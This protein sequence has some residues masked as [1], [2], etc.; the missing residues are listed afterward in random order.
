MTGGPAADLFP[1]FATHRVVTRGVEI[2]ARVGGSGP[3]LLLLHGYPQSHMMWHRVAGPLARHFTLVLPDL[4]GYGRSSCPPSDD[5]HRAYAKRTMALD[6]IAL[7]NS[8]KL[9]RFAVVG[10]DRGARVA[11]RLALDHPALVDRIMLLDILATPDQWSLREQATNLRMFHWAFLAQPAPLP[12]SLV[13]MDPV[14]WV[15]SRFK[16]GT[17]SGDVGIVDPIALDDYVSMMRDPDRVHATCE[18]YRAGARADLDDDEADRAAGRRIACP[19]LVL[20]GTHGQLADVIDPLA[21]WRPWCS[22]VAGGPLAAGHFIP[23]E[24]P[25]ALVDVLLPYLRGTRE[26]S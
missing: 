1:G 3:A 10:H 5:Q 20:W 14:D 11:Y 13:G 19:A 6:M 8:L 21:L 23:E 22:Q 24:N 16:R 4:R 26:E 7:M 17:L 18:D 2:F 25:Q 9:P 12:E 15:H